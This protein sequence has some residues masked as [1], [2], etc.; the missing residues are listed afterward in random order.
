M[1]DEGFKRLHDAVAVLERRA[2]EDWRRQ[3]HPSLTLEEAI[4]VSCKL[5][6]TTITSRPGGSTQVTFSVISRKVQDCEVT[7]FRL[8]RRGNRWYQQVLAPE[9]S[10]SAPPLTEEG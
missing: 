4:A 10:S 8:Q 7:H 5:M 2:I 1:N 3:H 6:E 9:T